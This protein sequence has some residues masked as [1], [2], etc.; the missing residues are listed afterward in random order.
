MPISHQSYIHQPIGYTPPVDLNVLGRTLQFKQ[1]QYDAGINKVQGL[2]DNAASLDVVKDSD[3]EYL[4][5]KLNNLVDTANNIGGADYSDP[6][7]SNQIAG[8]S[9]QIF[10]DPNIV[11]A[12]A[13]TKK[14]RYV[15]GYYKDLKEKKPKDW[16]PAN[17]WY[18]MN[19]FTDWLSDGQVGTSAQAGAGQV[20]PFVDYEKD[21]QNLFNK[22]TANMKSEITDKGMM[23]RIDTQ[24]YVSPQQI[25]DAAQKLLTPA[26]RRQLAIEG[27]YTY[28][29]VPI[30]QIA[31]SY[32]Q[33]VYD[34][35]GE[36]TSQLKDYQAKYKGA[37][38][39]QDQE[40]YQKL[41]D[42]K[43]NEINGLLAPVRK[44]ADQIKEKLYLN[45]K[46]SGLASRYAY[47][48]ATTKLQANTG[49]MFN[50]KFNLDKAKFAYQQGKDHIDQMI[51]IADKGL[52][53]TSDENGQPTL[54]ADPN[55]I[56]NRLKG[57]AGDGSNVYGG[58]PGVSNSPEEQSAT[59]TE[60][61][62]QDR[63]KEIDTDNSKLKDDFI[64]KLSFIKGLS[65]AVISD[66]RDNGH[67]D[68]NVDPQ[69]K[70]SVNSMMEALDRMTKGEKVNYERLDPMFKEFASRYQE[71]QAEANAI[72]EYNSLIDQQIKDKYGVSNPVVA[73]K[74]NRY[75]ELQKQ[76]AGLD[77]K[78]PY[79][80]DASGGGNSYT[81]GSS[82]G[83]RT[84][85]A[86]YAREKAAIENQ[87]K[88]EG[89]DQF[90]SDGN[91]RAYLLNK[92]KEK[93]DLIASAGVR[94][95]FMNVTQD[96]DKQHNI[97]KMI[98]GNAG[99]LQY[100]DENGSGGS[101]GTLSPD[102]IEPINKGYYSINGKKQP[103]MVFKYKTGSDP[104]DFKIYKVP[105]TP[106]QA[107]IL[108][109]GTEVRDLSG[110]NLALHLTGQ[111]RGV[112]TVSG[113]NYNLKY[114]MVKA[115]PLDQNDTRVFLR[116]IKNG[117]PIILNNLPPF[118]TYEAAQK[119]MEQQTKYKSI[120]DAFYYLEQ[121]AKK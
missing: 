26:Q 88:A 38:D 43:S 16:N 39:I 36:A 28:D 75:A 69:L 103:A 73:A 31:K 120:D 32:D 96:D 52:M 115:D 17:E 116:V 56:K 92:D 65:P 59:F 94:Y 45:E 106:A 64:K 20:T 46:L 23:Y 76:L 119:F 11:N 13:N 61:T 105:L 67:I 12:V 107:Q 19:K 74:L 37:T 118:A 101:K 44:S 68:A 70:E 42:E 93:K 15:Q 54:V 49:A 55:S 84:N 108:G 117:N 25:Y 72:D 1:A 83:Y 77:D 63:R 98:A 114:D 91:Q 3:R 102:N 71:N 66:L 95:N 60:S 27:R 111:A 85:A 8:L 33:K 9:S 51:D 57:K 90:V 10:G 104:T 22:M 53:W 18:D 109:F 112:N 6:N 80:G 2:L 50:A 7:V 78:Y 86:D 4:N 87:I 47:T 34:K 97:A 48:Q 100:Y 62:L 35:V 99:T 41:I 58:I 79:V 121:A 30:S 113:D 110:Y 89:L 40:K 5:T 82:G 21:W 14:F 29:G 24:K 81:A